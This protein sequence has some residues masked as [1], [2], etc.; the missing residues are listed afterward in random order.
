MVFVRGDPFDLYLVAVLLCCV[1][2][3]GCYVLDSITLYEA[4]G[5]LVYAGAIVF[6]DGGG[7]LQLFL[8]CCLVDMVYQLA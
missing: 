1:E 7:S 4:L 5:Y 3:L 6:V 2:K 8:P